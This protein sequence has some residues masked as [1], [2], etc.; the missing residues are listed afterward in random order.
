MQKKIIPFILSTALIIS[1]FFALCSIGNVQG[2]ARVVNYTGIVRGA[3]QKL[4]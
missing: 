4:V 3:T 1:V 2:N